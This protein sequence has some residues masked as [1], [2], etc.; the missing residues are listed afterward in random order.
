MGLAGS[1]FQ[2][3]RF[4]WA[5]YLCTFCIG[6]GHRRK[7]RLSVSEGKNVRLAK[8]CGPA[9]R[10]PLVI[11]HNLAHHIVTAAFFTMRLGWVL[12][13]GAAFFAGG[14]FVRL[15]FS[16]RSGFH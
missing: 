8:P 3:P 7:T 5:D 12:V 15:L 16:R 1:W 14:L 6:Q 10:W 9:P 4:W 2:Q 13:P 11:G